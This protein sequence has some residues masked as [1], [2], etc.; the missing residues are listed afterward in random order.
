MLTKG[1]GS[2]PG[3]PAPVCGGHC[4]RFCQGQ[5]WQKPPELGSAP[6]GRL[7]RSEAGVSFWQSWQKPAS[8]QAIKP[9]RLSRICPTGPTSWQACPK[10]S[11]GFPLAG[12]KPSAQASA[13]GRT[14]RI[15]QSWQK[16]SSNEGSSE[17]APISWQAC[18]R[19]S[20][21]VPLA[22]LKPV[23]RVLLWVELPEAPRAGRSA[24]SRICPTGPS[25]WRACPRRSRGCLP[26]GLAAPGGCTGF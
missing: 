10:Q 2:A 21:G 1:P 4:T 24:L 5:D 14:G 13:V 26:A 7:A 12:P 11:R 25:S 3:K 9:S 23:H 22:G 16:P 18:P 15:P 20:R 8:Q 19:R 6:S 17:S